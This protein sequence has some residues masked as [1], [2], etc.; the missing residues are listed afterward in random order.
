M[1]TSSPALVLAVHGS[2]DPAAAAVTGLLADAVTALGGVRP[3]VGC[4]EERQPAPGVRPGPR[5]PSLDGLLDRLAGR[6]QERAVVV[7]L[8]LGDGFHRRVDV[9]AVLAKP[10]TLR[11]TLTR[12]LSGEPDVALALYDR[13][14]AAEQAAGGR[15][16]AVVL[17]SAGSRRPDGTA[18]ARIAA[19]QLRSLLTAAH[20]G[21]PA[22]PV[23][24]AYCSA[25]RPT[26]PEAVAGLRA[27]GHRRVAVA[28]HLLA[29]G[30]F[31]G[32]LRDAGAW[33]V[34]E[35]LGAHPRIARL[36]VRRYTRAAGVAHHP[37][38]A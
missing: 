14:R 16:D 37:A 11:C 38:A 27:A 7:P 20:G 22:V 21:E 4:L 2:A 28:T 33:A 9:P 32:E 6:G 35:P 31:S 5:W 24:P 12:G 19:G 13:L 17:A 10:R 34:A 18:G 26:V 30:R 29:P 15:A 8:L 36:V 25:A 3:Q 1:D 23:P